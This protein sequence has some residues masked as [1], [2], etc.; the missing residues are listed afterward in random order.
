M[1]EIVFQILA[2]GGSLAIERI[3]EKHIPRFIY[4]HGEIDLI[5]EE[6]NINRQIDFDSFEEPFQIINRKYPWYHLCVERVHP[7]YRDYVV[8]ELVKMLNLNRVNPESL[9]F[10]KEYLEQALKVQLVFGFAPV[11]SGLKEIKIESLTKF[12]KFEY[13]QN[14]FGL[15]DDSFYTRGEAPGWSSETWITSNQSFNYGDVRRCVQLPESIN[16]IG[17]L[18]VNGNTV[19]VLDENG[20]MVY[21]FSSDKFF[22]SAFPLI[23]DEEMWFYRKVY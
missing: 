18:E 5:D 12:T 6:T 16:T 17:K 2:E 19:T 15:I 4:H 11:K 9:E 8:E 1:S 20:E 7:D 23:G 22:V 14:N 13:N 3:C 21:V 10:A